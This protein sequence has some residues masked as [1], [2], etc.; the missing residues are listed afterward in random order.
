MQT[1]V[2]RQAEAVQTSVQQAV[3]HMQAEVSHQIG[4]QI[5]AQFERLEALL[6]KRSRSE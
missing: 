2:A 1:E 3:G 5:T 4:S 6:A